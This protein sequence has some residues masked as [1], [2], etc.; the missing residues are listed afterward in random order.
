VSVEEIR[1][2]HAAAGNTEW[3]HWPHDPIPHRCI[4]DGKGNVIATV[5]EKSEAPLLSEAIV[6]AHNDITEL[7][8]ENE[9]LVR[10]QAFADIALT[11]RWDPA[12]GEWVPRRP[13]EGEPNG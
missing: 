11:H 5:H 10:A 9:R 2:R 1:S 6:H 4:S 3:E 8:A 12:S 7:L 13:K